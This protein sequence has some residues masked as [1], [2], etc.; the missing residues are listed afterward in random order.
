[1][2]EPLRFITPEIIGRI[3]DGTF[4]PAR[5]S[6]NS[7]HM[8]DRRDAF[9]PLSITKRYVRYEADVFQSRKDLILKMAH[10]LNDPVKK[11]MLVGGVQGSGK[12]SLVR[13]LIELM[14]SRNEQLL[15][16]D[17]NRHTDFDE[18]IEFLIQYITY[19]CLSLKA[20]PTESPAERKPDQGLLVDPLKR[21]DALIAQ[22]EDMPLL[23]VLD[24]VEYL[25]DS[26]LRFSSFPFK[27][28]LNF[29]LGFPNIKMILLGER[30]PYADMNPRQDSLE[31]IRLEG[32]TEA[33]TV[34]F[35]Q[36]RK[37]P[38]PKALPDT[39]ILEH[40][41]LPESEQQAIRQIY[42]KT[43]GFPWL[44]K[45][46][47]YLNHQAQHDF[48]TLSRLLDKSGKAQLGEN[49]LPV[50]ELVRHI[51]HL[52]P[53]QH[54][55]LFQVLCVLRHPVDAKTLL[56]MVEICY[57]TLG[58]SGLSVQS[59]ED[60]LEHS[61]LRVLLKINYP[62]QEVL[63]HI[64]GRQ[65][66]RPSPHK[67]APPE[68]HNTARKFRP[69]YELYHQVKKL[70]Y[71]NIPSTERERLHGI[72][73]DF[74]LREKSNSP[75]SRSIKLKNR[76]FISESKYHGSFSRE[77]KVGGTSLKTGIAFS[78][79]VENL[80]GQML[81]AQP[82]GFVP[83]V[84]AFGDDL[85]KRLPVQ[86][87]ELSSGHP[88]SGSEAF[89][90]RLLSDDA[91]TSLEGPSFMELLKRSSG[92][93]TVQEELASLNLTPEEQAILFPQ[94]GQAPL[95][96][97]LPSASE[98]EKKETI[99]PAALVTPQQDQTDDH[100]LAENHPGHPP[101]HTE[102]QQEKDIRERLTA[103]V[104]SRNKPAMLSELIALARYRANSG[105]YESAGHCLEKA[106]TLKADADK[107]TV[108]EIYRLSGSVYKETYH[109]NAALTYL[110]KA[111]EVIQRLMFEDDTVDSAW[112]GRLGKTYQDIGEI[113]EYRGQFAQAQEAF[114]QAL[115]WYHSSDD[116]PQQAE[117]NFRLAGVLE[118]QN[119]ADEAILHYQKA[120][121]IDQG[122]DN[123]LS[124]AASLANLG[125]LYRRSSRW[126]EAL[127][128]FQQSF[129]CDQESQNLD[130]QLNTLSAMIA[131]HLSCEQYQ[132]AETLAK[133]G[134]ALAL[135]YYSPLWQSSFYVKLAQVDECLQNVSRAA[136]YYQLA[137][138]SGAQELSSDSLRWIEQKLA[139]VQS[140][141]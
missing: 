78:P 28:M 1:M 2:P 21:L 55:R 59:L 20:N 89:P 127:D 4:V 46:L 76:A 81:N 70:L 49:A 120:L 98:I 141:S 19:I 86:S 99:L 58:P 137:L 26:E 11:I 108:A 67:T 72:L 53:D 106:L 66:Q 111:A 71:N 8:N 62:P 132:T 92:H 103:A 87:S 17:A 24:N 117:V 74:Y 22:V 93:L 9:S 94:S 135:Q 102:D 121:S 18:I 68:G 97:D 124:A 80:A 104:A 114:T 52:L 91:E 140:S 105:R 77:R 101:K 79:K 131:V 88:I 37:K 109:H 90:E 63:S 3:S 136:H 113:Y 39:A 27:E 54:R 83:D 119:L 96:S 41:A 29:L 110:S 38:G 112:M 118:D 7:L 122:N 35:L 45:I 44:L 51:Y 33:D 12:T 128:C 6:Q 125:N 31:D 69:G 73:Q 60:M 134:L 107:P 126:T 130:G 115:R 65:E 10:S 139:S 32:L 138:S 84:W 23:L 61:S 14:G 30:L 43:S 129:A 75:E 82:E 40:L 133:Q 48:L 116:L 25:V 47:T 95:F 50:L 123:K 100:W 5:R 85:P 36:S 15:W 56:R 42:G 16:F 57:P 34:G 64:R 13:G